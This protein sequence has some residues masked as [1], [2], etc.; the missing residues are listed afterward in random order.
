MSNA[1]LAPTQF[2]TPSPAQLDD[3]L[4][5]AA[6]LLVSPEGHADDERLN[7]ACKL[8]RRHCP[9]YWLDD[10]DVRPFWAVT[11]YDDIVSVERRSA[12]FTVEARALFS[13]EAA[14]AALSQMAGKPQ[15]IRGLINMDEP[16]H[17]A[18]RA[19]TQTRFTPGGLSRFETYL[20][21]LAAK[22]IDEMANRGGVCDFAEDVAA[23]F[24]CAVVTHLL[25][26]PESDGPLLQR[27]VR[28]VVA[29]NDPDRCKAE[30]P[31]EAIRSGM[32]GLRDYFN[33]LVGDRRAT[34]RE[35]LSSVLANATIRGMPL[36]FYE[37]ISYYVLLTTAGFDSSAFAMSG[38]LHALMT[39]GQFARLRQAP[40]LLDSAI[41]EMLRWTSPARSIIR[42]AREDVDVGGVV[43]RAGEAVALF[44]N[45][46]NRDEH[47]F[48]D[49][50]IFLIDR[51]PNPHLAFGRGIHHCLGHHLVRMEMR[52]LFA[53]LLRRVDRVEL[54][55]TTRRTRSAVIT[56]ISSLPILFG[57]A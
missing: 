35:D 17:G 10:G 8:L 9:V 39:S 6:L 43:I 40:H 30:L 27:L 49:A 56:G 57:L 29:P 45:S 42:T 31:T 54:A 32:L 38:G 48:P 19:L 2:E 22:V 20:T 7:S 55:G 16:D 12:A 13:G 18:Y 15:I 5:E 1:T 37:S 21:E 50:D 52:A 51:T 24:S 3:A 34:P 46:A 53:E 33:T 4:H 41:E 25:G 23:R 36:P 11:R 14:E 44:F 28:G 47:I 26:V